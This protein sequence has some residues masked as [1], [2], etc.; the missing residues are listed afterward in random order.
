MVREGRTVQVLK[1]HKS[2]HRPLHPHA[3]PLAPLASTAELPA[4][5]CSRRTVQGFSASWKPLVLQHLS[6]G[7]K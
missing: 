7:S 3:A 2:L 5:D 4:P 1:Q 6:V